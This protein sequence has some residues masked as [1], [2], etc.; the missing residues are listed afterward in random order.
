M[1]LKQCSEISPRIDS[2]SPCL[3]YVPDTW[4][5]LA[6]DFDFSIV[7]RLTRQVAHAR[8]LGS[9]VPRLV[10]PSVHEVNEVIVGHAES[11]LPLH[12]ITFERRVVSVEGSRKFSDYW[13]DFIVE[14]S[15]IPGL[16]LDDDGFVL[17]EIAEG[18]NF[19]VW[20]LIGNSRRLEIYKGYPF[21]MASGKVFEIF[22]RSRSLPSADAEFR[23]FRCRATRIPTVL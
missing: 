22:T 13:N 1:S 15:L 7:F 3:A 17:A 14:R 23:I 2:G 11:E 21:C 18:H 20:R 9:G 8:L 16:S 12:N 19:A 10:A 4:N 6:S 5:S